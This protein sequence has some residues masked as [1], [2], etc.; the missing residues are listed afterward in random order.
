MILC[1]SSPLAIGRSSHSS[2]RV[3]TVVGFPLRLRSLVGVVAR[4]T[5]RA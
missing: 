4:A 2:E 3:P 1:S 5:I